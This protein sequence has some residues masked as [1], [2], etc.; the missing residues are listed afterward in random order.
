MQPSPIGESIAAVGGKTNAERTQTTA[1]RTRLTSERAQISRRL[2]GLYNAIADGLRTTGLQQK[3]QDMAA[4]LS[5][6]DAKLAE[7][8]PSPVRFHPQLSEI[9]RRKVTNLAEKLK[10]P[11]IR[12]M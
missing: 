2:D 10:D 3:M 11:K 6:V 7:P 8:M 12:P 4:K 9:Y 1:E 5:E